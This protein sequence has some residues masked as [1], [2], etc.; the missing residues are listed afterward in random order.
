MLVQLLMIAVNSIAADIR[1]LILCI[2]I[3]V[4]ADVAGTTGYVTAVYAF[5]CNSICVLLLVQL[6]LYTVAGVAATVYCC[7]CS[8]N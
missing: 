7:W 4:A 5:R 3:V 6:Q 2:I 1:I 8:C